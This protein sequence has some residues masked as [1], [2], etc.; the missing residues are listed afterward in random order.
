MKQN[1]FYFLLLFITFSSIGYAQDHYY[2]YRG[3][4]VAL[5]KNPEKTYITFDA[6]INTGELEKIL[7]TPMGTPRI[8]TGRMGV[9]GS[10]EQGNNI[11][12]QL[13]WAIVETPEKNIVGHSEIN[14]SA[15]FYWTGEGVE[16][17]LSNLF[18]VKLK[19]P[20]D[21]SL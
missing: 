8:E 19:S 6:K 20:D 5:R 12:S 21:R 10:L 14:Y 1:Y 18:Y 13:K 15:S 11:D 9:S 4:K 3:E 16:A 2:W 17:G 7:G